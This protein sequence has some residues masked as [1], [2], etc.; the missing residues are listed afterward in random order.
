VKIDRLVK[1]VYLIL[2]KMCEMDKNSSNIPLK[3][4][5]LNLKLLGNEVKKVRQL[6]ATEV[7]LS[8]KIRLKIRFIETK[9]IW[10]L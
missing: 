2:G 5:M 4:G 7:I 6:L 9:T 8:G 1:L 3:I 10:F